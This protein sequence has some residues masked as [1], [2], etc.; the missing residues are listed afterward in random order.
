MKGEDAGARQTWV[1]ILPP[2]LCRSEILGMLFH[3]SEPQFPYL[4]NGHKNTYLSG[5]CG[6]A[7]RLPALGTEPGVL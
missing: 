4:Q 2:P 5:L 7:T 3:L 1:Q 6:D